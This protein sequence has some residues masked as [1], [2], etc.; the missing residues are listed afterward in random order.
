MICVLSSA[1]SPTRCSIESGIANT[2]ARWCASPDHRR[3]RPIE[4]IRPSRA[5]NRQAQAGAA[6]NGS[7]P[8]MSEADAYPQDCLG[9]AARKNRS[10]PATAVSVAA[11]NSST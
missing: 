3:S 10:P 7:W 8:P 6:V 9:V 2:L 1:G 4:T 11:R 5:G